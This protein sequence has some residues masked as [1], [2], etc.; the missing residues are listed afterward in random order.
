LTAVA[1]ETLVAAIERHESL[2]EEQTVATDR[3]KALDYYLGEKRGDEIDGRSQVISRDVFDTV[4]W[5][6]PQISDIFCAGE[7]VINFC[8]RGP[9]DVK[10][11]EQETEFV[12]Y[13][14]TQKNNWFK[15]FY[16]WSHD[17]LLQKTGYVKAYWD[18]HTDR[19]KERYKGLTD[20]EL[21]VLFE[22]NPPGVAIN[23]VAHEQTPEGHNITIEK[24][25]TYGCVKLHNV[26]PERVLIDH[27]ARGIDLQDPRL[28]FVE[29]R[30]E[31]TISELRD[32]GF[33]VEDDLSDAGD[34]ASNWEET[35]RSENNPFRGDDE[36]VDPS[37]R[38]LMVRECWIRFDENDD[39][40][41]ELLHVVIVGTTVLLKEEADLV[42][43][44]ALSP[45]PLPHKHHGLSLADAV[46]DLQDIKTALLRGSLDNVYLANNGRHAIDDSIV[47]LD[48]MLVSRPG[49]AVRVK[50]N[51]HLAIM[52][53]NHSTMGDVGMKTMEYIDR[54]KT[55]RTGVNEQSQ[56]LDSN[57]INKNTPYATTS[58]LMS[59]AQQRIRFIARIFAETGV[60]SLFQVVHALTMHH[61]RQAEIIQ[62]R[63][64]WVPIDP[65]QWQ[66]RTDMQIAVGLGAGDKPQQ[67][68]FLEKV[69]QIQTVAVAQGLSDKTKVYN[70]LKRLSQVAGFKDP[71]EFWTD[72]STQPPQPPAPDP[73]VMK[74][75]AKA[76]A[77]MQIE[78]GKAQTTKEVEAMKAQLKLQ[79][80]RGNLELQASNDQRDSEREMMRAQMDAADREKQRQLDEWKAQLQ[81]QMDKYKADLQATVQLQIAGMNADTSLSNTVLSNQ[82]QDKQAMQQLGMKAAELERPVKDTE[83]IKAAMGEV[84]KQMR[85]LAKQ[86][87]ALDDR[88]K[89]PAKIIRG[90]DGKAI[91]V[92]IGGVQ[93]QV[94][95]D[96][97][98]KIQSLQ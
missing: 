30:E 49:G 15:V 68:M 60:K 26:A 6:K 56:G 73:E 74:E 37:T 53:L 20:E 27:N 83:T 34:G 63:N 66:K 64:Q 77:Q 7:E 80:L 33:D 52:P 76:Q 5:I 16:D 67:M 8:P 25:R 91:A 11:A 92:D 93:R 43:L 46:F 22:A 88:A 2:A 18:D 45:T 98:G 58:A 69:L 84:Q 40:L 94:V 81:A 19:N 24:A 57:T 29:Q 23:V 55:Q 96:A 87:K 31:K 17:A 4:E 21:V 32:E 10:A 1:D 85:E 12:N 42:P 78:A 36:G 65:R 95:R 50:G 70:A 47:N 51:P 59:A 28:A 35:N 44:V 71:N 86:Q 3:E 90:E 48:D 79:E 41:A 13:V 61:S 14:I 97:S 62:L 89:Q 72:P 39:G 82:Q 75:Q 54:I 38:R 9:E